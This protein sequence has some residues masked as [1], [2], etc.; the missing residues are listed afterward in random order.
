MDLAVHAIETGDE[1]TLEC[2]YNTDLFD[3]GTVRR[4]LASYEQLL[5]S[6]IAEPAAPLGRLAI[7]TRED[8]A[9]LD[10]CNATSRAIPADLLVHELVEAEADRAP[11]RVAVEQDGV[12]LR[13]D[14]LNARANQLAHHL[15][16]LGVQRGELVGLLLDRTPDTIIALLAVLK[17]GAGYVP[18]DPALPV[19]RLER[20]ATDAALAAL[21]TNERIRDDINIS[22]RELVSIDGDAGVI[23][24]S[25]PTNPPRDEHT[26]RPSDTAYVIFTSGSTGRPKGVLVPHIGLLNLA[27]S[28]RHTP[29]M[30]RDDV[31]LAITTL[32]FDVAVSEVLLPLTLGARIVLASRETAAD[33][34]KLRRVVESRAVTVICSAPATYHL[35]LEAGWTGDPRLMIICTGEAMPR[36][37]AAALVHCGRAVWNAYGPSETTVWSMFYRV[38]APVQR[39][40]IGRPVDNTCVAVR[41]LH[42]EQ[43]PIG[44]VGELVIGGAGVATGYL[45]LDETT[46]DR[47]QADPHQPGLRWYHTGDLAR[48]LASGDLECLGRMDDQV[49][50]RGYRIEPGEI[51]VVVSQWPGVR[52]TVVIAREDRANDVRLIAY[53]IADPATRFDDAFR[54]YLKRI[55]PQYMVPA[56]VVV[57]DAF[58][59]TASG[60]VDRKRLPAPSAAD[61]S[62]PADFVAPRTPTEGML[63]GIWEEALGGRVGIHDD[64]FA[65]GGHSLLA[66][67]ILSR[68]RRDQGVDLSFRRIFESP[69]VELLA[70]VIDDGHTARSVG[71]NVIDAGRGAD[72][73]VR[74]AHTLTAPLTAQQERLWMLEEL[75]PR[76]RWAHSHP[77]AWNLHG[78]LDEE[79][80][81]TALQ[82]LMERHPMLRTS[83][84]WRDG[85]REQQIHE[86]VTVTLAR[87]DLSH[88]PVEGQ[89]AALQACFAELHEVPFDIGVAPLFRATLVALGR[90]RHQLYTLQHGLI[91]DGW[92]FDL[93]VRD[94]GELYAATVERRSP[95]L[96]PLSVTL[97]DFADWQQQW[98]DGPEAHAQQAWW[99]N[100]L[101]GVDEAVTMPTDR[102]RPLASSYAGDYVSISFTTDDV[103]ALHRLAR[104]YDGTLYMV[105]L[106]AYSALLH[107]YTGQRDLL[108]ASPMRARTQT[109]LEDVLG[110]FVNAVVLRVHIDAAS[111][112]ADLVRRVR[113]TALDTYAHQELPFELLGGQLPAIRTVF[114]LQ[115]A[116]ER[117]RTFGLLDVELAAVPLQFAANDLTLWMQQYPTHTSAV[118]NFSTELFDR[119]SA[120]LF[121]D[122]FRALLTAVLAEPDLALARL[123][124][125]IGADGDTSAALPVR[126]TASAPSP[127]VLSMIARVA[128][129]RTS[130]IA[131][132]ASSARE[133]F[134]AL[135]TRAGAIAA[136]LARRGI[137]SDAVVAVSLPS[138]VESVVAAL[139]VLRAGAQLLTISP[140]DGVEF[141][142]RV[143]TA[144][145]PM[146]RIGVRADAGTVGTPPTVTLAVLAFEGE[147]TAAP[148]VVEGDAGLVMAWT[149][150]D[151][152]VRIMRI[153]M[154]RIDA[155]ADAISAALTLTHDVSV[156]F[157]VPTGAA[158]HCLSLLAV[159]AGGARLVFADEAAV[160]DAHDLSGDVSA[161]GCTRLIATAEAW[162]TTL[163]GGWS[164][165]AFERGLLVGGGLSPHEMSDIVSRGTALWSASGGEHDGTASALLAVGAHEQHGLLGTPIGRGAFRVVDGQDRP[166]P[167]GMRG[168]LAS[169]RA[170]LDT[171]W[172]RTGLAARRTVHGAFQLLAGAD[173]TVWRDGVRVNTS[174]LEVII[175]RVPGVADAAV[176][177]HV[178]AR[179]RPWLVAHVVP[180][181]GWDVGTLR[182]QC[183]SRLPAAWLPTRFVAAVTLPWTADGSVD[184]A[185]LPSP[186]DADS[187]AADQPRTASERDLMDVWS[188]VLGVSHVG[189]DDNFFARGGTSLS[190]FRAIELIRRRTKVRLS[191]RVLLTGTLAQ[192]AEELAGEHAVQHAA[193]NA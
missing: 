64:F 118:L 49:K 2:Q 79:A 187:S 1:I 94:L 191:P 55:L 51:A 81:Q 128:T 111:S 141:Q 155:Q 56:A 188:H 153:P 149:D 60:K 119:A 58:P 12:L 11:D 152:G 116:R 62:A 133:T 75:E 13:Y 176:R 97:G 45:N 5:R 164:A 165:A 83:F 95:I 140:D 160:D 40:L 173:S 144:T 122:Q 7:R 4:W 158:A 175:R 182:A 61:A 168:W 6:A 96:A 101:A 125:E 59:L 37:L 169:A 32:V 113:D 127:S 39:V 157:A 117:P 33:G 147:G 145:S 121:L 103:S 146:L 52:Q 138:S 16:G 24:L 132:Q 163:S 15:R 69:T 139:G 142:S 42:G 156:C 107:R 148:T 99:N 66:S 41:D 93:F 21:I 35:L 174:V 129:E 50:V 193:V 106:A 47:F 159:L 130:A 68:L 31:V 34:T 135:W 114:S 109:E 137:G 102:P 162:R 28:L 43:V 184:R 112:F 10:R 170:G 134:G 36:E 84:H 38:E 48:V 3:A 18:L 178:D 23:A 126:A 9:A 190:C 30:H 19:E 186:F 20:M 100:Q 22:A 17:A 72:V 161:A 26:A 67:Q 65:L 104:R 172:V 180:E 90:D 183:R 8:E 14:E 105:L 123:V 171:T 86:H 108:V 110:P 115:D 98:L 57:M 88:T 74:R 25:P 192:A 92:S 136:A 76:R 150:V 29:G 120:Q 77:A 80:L 44:V 46:A 166:T 87:V 89:A 181:A 124:L 71:A 185:A 63:V 78:P 179:G 143:L 154:A 53:V 151:G 167:V 27:L 189:R 131:V 54:A 82:A 91:W 85:N 177:V 70:R 73:I